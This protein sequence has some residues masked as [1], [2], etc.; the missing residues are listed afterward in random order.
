MIGM[1]IK[2]ISVLNLRHVLKPFVKST[3]GLFSLPLVRGYAYHYTMS[4]ALL[5]IFC[6]YFNENILRTFRWNDTYMIWK[7]RN[8]NL[9]SAAGQII[10]KELSVELIRYN[11]GTNIISYIK[12][13]D[14][15][16][17]NYLNLKRR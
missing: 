12:L 6:T 1:S 10:P 3:P 17:W 14:K 15:Y 4:N 2:R 5:C 13:T 11:F 8:E 9:N 16:L 7:I